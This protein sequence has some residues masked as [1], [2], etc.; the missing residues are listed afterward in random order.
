MRG[1]SGARRAN[2]PHD[3]PHVRPCI[4]STTANPRLLRTR[5]YTYQCKCSP[6][7]A[8]PRPCSA[9]AG[10][11]PPAAPL[12]PAFLAVYALP[13]IPRRPGPRRPGPHRPGPRRDLG[14]TILR[15]QLGHRAPAPARRHHRVGVVALPVP[16]GALRLPVHVIMVPRGRVEVPIVLRGRV[17]AHALI[18]VR[19]FP[20]RAATDLPL[21][22]RESL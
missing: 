22:V 6:G 8:A 15:P 10:P 19:T 9:T 11:T 17:A 4:S 20:L 18:K 16:V 21:M 2:L 12:F 7:D 14:R 3:L 13:R 1:A 5:V